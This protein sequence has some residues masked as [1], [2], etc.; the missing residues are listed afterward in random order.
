MTTR[1]AAQLLGLNKF[2]PTSS[3]IIP[4]TFTGGVE[5]DI[6]NISPGAPGYV[7]SIRCA[8]FDFTSVVNSVI[9][10]YIDGEG[11]PSINCDTGTLL[12]ANV[13]A[14]G[15]YSIKHHAFTYVASHCGVFNFMYPIPYKSSI[16]ITLTVSN[17]CTAS[18]TI[19]YYNGVQ[20]PYKLISSC[21]K[22]SGKQTY[23]PTQQS[24]QTVKFLNLGAGN[25]GWIA[26][27]CIAGDASSDSTWMENAPVMF[28]D[29]ASLGGSPQ[30]NA[31]GMEEYFKTS[32]S[33]W[34]GGITQAQWS[35]TS[36][37]SNA[38]GIV[39]AA[40]DLLALYG[41]IKFTNGI[42]MC[43]QGGAKGTP[44]DANVDL[45]WLVLYYVANP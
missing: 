3:V 6:L 36:V 34:N 45:A 39:T 11:S 41:G 40:I 30:Y 13:G 21:Q 37:V 25:A 35:T 2:Q 14:S 9:K 23:S 19:I 31:G 22:Y 29:G 17:T 5:T 33:Y 7:A 44:S 38:T 27:H 20:I 28:L 1:G 18:P 8:I 10:V 43:L 15:C 16:R 12:S 32:G 42:V 24:N 26:Y 4:S